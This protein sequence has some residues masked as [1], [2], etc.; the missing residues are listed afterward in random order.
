M[1]EKQDRTELLAN[2][3]TAAGERTESALN[4]LNEEK[5]QAL[6][7]ALA[8]GAGSEKQNGIPKAER[9]ASQEARRP[10]GDE[11]DK[12]SS[13]LAIEAGTSRASMIDIT[14]LHGYSTPR[15]AERG[16]REQGW[17]G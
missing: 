10:R 17:R 13:F 2:F 6:S 7:E 14:R 11:K 3:A 1:K 5:R 16:E 4:K 12:T 8:S 9:C 15:R